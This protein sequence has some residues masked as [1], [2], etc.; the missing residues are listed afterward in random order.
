MSAVL[1]LVTQSCLA[2][3]DSMDCSLPGSSVC[4]DSPGKNT[5]VGCHALLQRTF[6]TL[7][8]NLG[9]PHCRRIL[10]H[11][12]H[13]GRPA[14]NILEYNFALC[15]YVL[16]LVQLFVTPWT[17]ACLCPWN[18]LGKNIGV[19]CHFLLQWVFL[20]QGLNPHLLCLLHWQEDS[21]PL[22]FLTWEALK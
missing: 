21:L 5:G 8:S 11:L 16:S 6:P 2:L 3:C 15:V 10:Y 18:F 22:Q 4:G 14:V 12:I 9:L 7:G 1:C 19:G 20:T 13:Q 17:I